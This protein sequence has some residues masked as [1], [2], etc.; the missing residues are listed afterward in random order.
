VR[1]AA[2]AAH[3]SGHV[4]TKTATNTSGPVTPPPTILGRETQVQ[5]AARGAT[6]RGGSHELVPHFLG[7][8]Q[9]EALAILSRLNQGVTRRVRSRNQT[10]EAETR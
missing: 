3:A 6:Q 9:S 8:T 10:G 7:Q 5:A 4:S 1:A 2:G